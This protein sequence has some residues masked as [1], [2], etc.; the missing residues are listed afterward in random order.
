MMHR[1]LQQLRVQM[2]AQLPKL[3]SLRMAVLLRV[4]HKLQA[5]WHLMMLTM[6]RPRAGHARV[7]KALHT[8]PLL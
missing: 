1:W 5:R 8:A 7:Q 4:Q 3:A 6:I 2:K